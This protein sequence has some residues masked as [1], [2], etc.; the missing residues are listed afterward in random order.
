MCTR[1][2]RHHR[3][4]GFHQR[5]QQLQA[6]R[7]ELDR[8]AVAVHGERVEVVGEVGHLQHAALRALAAARQHLQPRGQFLQRERLGHVVVGA[9]LEA[10]E[11]LLQRVARGQ[12]QHRGLLVR[13][14]A[15]LA[16]HVQAVHARQGEVEH[17]HVEVVHH[18]Q[19]QSGHTVACEIHDVAAVFQVV[20]DVGRDI[21][22]VF[23]HKDTHAPLQRPL[24]AKI[25]KLNKL[26]T[27]AAGPPNNKRAAGSRSQ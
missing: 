15:Q 25:N 24:A 7:V 11:L 14:V 27:R 10:G 22:V 6:D 5:L 3:G 1:R 12:H 19:V 13:L 8:L 16:R 17:D 21:A 23:D 20:A 4:A 9:G 26:A 18:G 2:P